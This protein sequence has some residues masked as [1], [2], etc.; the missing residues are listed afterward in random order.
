MATSGL[1]GAQDHAVRYSK[2]H[3]QATRE[4]IIEAAGM[5]DAGE[6]LDP[7]TAVPRRPTL[8]PNAHY[9]AISLHNVTQWHIE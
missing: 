8:A 5:S 9:G 3:K 6:A 4:R 1:G 2:E 7:E